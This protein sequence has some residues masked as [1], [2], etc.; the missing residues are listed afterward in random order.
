MTSRSL[1]PTET[2]PKVLP[3]WPVADAGAMASAVRPVSAS[4]MEVVMPGPCHAPALWADL[5]RFAY[6]AYAAAALR[7]IILL[8]ARS[9]FE[10]ST[11]STEAELT[12]STLSPPGERFIVPPSLTWSAAAESEPPFQLTVPRLMRFVVVR[13]AVPESVYVP[14]APVLRLRTDMV[15]PTLR[16][17]PLWT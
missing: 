8:S 9:S 16:L 13:L 10:P 7:T 14:P 2:P 15:V 1:A 11:V 12:T 3:A 17:P 4:G 6:V 5:M